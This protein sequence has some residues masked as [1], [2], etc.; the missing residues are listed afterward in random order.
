MKVVARA[1]ISLALERVFISASVSA[2]AEQ[3]RERIEHVELSSPPIFF[4]L[5][6]VTEVFFFF[7][8]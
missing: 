6:G 7:S 5:R 4:F 2:R 8:F 1:V 3:Q